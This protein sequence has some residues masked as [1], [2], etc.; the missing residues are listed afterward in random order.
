MKSVNFAEQRIEKI[1]ELGFLL[2]A[3]DGRTKATSQ[4][5]TL[6]FNLHNYFNPKRAEYSKHCNTCV[7][8]VYKQ[9]KAIYQQVKDEI[10]S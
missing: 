10:Q 7:A 5:L 4:E 3:L 1:K 2:S 9:A 6:L 8:R